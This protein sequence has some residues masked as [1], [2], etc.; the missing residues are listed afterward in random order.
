M[1]H[2]HMLAT[3]SKQHLSCSSRLYE[4]SQQELA[5]KLVTDALCSNPINDV[6]HEAGIAHPI[7]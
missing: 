6:T 7:T 2:G 3:S 5:L 4:I 1:C